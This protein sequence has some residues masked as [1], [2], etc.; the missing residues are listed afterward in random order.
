ME[1][2]LEKLK[3]ILREMGSVLVAFSGGLDS[4]FLLKVAQDTLGTKACAITA[5]SPT[6]SKREFEDSKKFCRDFGIKQ[7]L[8]E[9]SEMDLPDFRRNPKN[10]CYLCKSDL[11]SKCKEKAKEKGFAYVADGANVDDLSDFRPGSQAAKE[12]GI[13][14]PLLEAGFTKKD[15]RA[16][17][18][19]LN[20]PT[21]DKPSYACLA[22]RFPYGEDISEERLAA[23]EKLEDFIRDLGFKQVRV[24]DHKSVARIEVEPED[25]P[26]LIE[27]E[28]T[29]ERISEKAKESGFT[30]ITVD[31][32]GYRTGSMNE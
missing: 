27:D 15:I 7:I 16:E 2:K 9:S 19:L 17:S 26:R 3:E 8:I 20:L 32:D 30:Y 23:I 13:R 5:T 22:S 29:R 21:W 12:L 4:S 10:R 11:F 31:L 14:R 1:D 24:R 6:Y 18:K 28:D 25:I